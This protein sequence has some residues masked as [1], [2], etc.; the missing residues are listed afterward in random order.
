MTPHPIDPVDLSAYHDGAL[1]EADRRRVEEHLSVCRSCRERLEDY[2]WLGDALREGEDVPVPLTLDVRVRA[3][4]REHSAPRRRLPLPQ[5]WLPRPAMAAAVLAGLAM[6]LLLA[7]IPIL[8]SGSGPL[9]AAAYLYEEHGE[10]A[11]EVQF[12]APVDRDSVARSLQVDP[13]VEMEVT[14]RND[15]TMVV[16]PRQPQLLQP[17]K[18]YTLSLKPKGEQSAATPVALQFQGEV[19]STPVPLATQPAPTSP[20]ASRVVGTG[21]ATPKASA[22]AS[23]TAA[24]TLSPGGA[25]ALT[26]TPRP[27]V[28]P[29]RGFGALYLLQPDVAARLGPAYDPERP[30]T[31]LAQTFE[32]GQLISRADRK[33]IVALLE[34]SQW[35][36][37]PDTYDGTESWTPGSGE[38]VRSFGKLW[39]DQ[40]DLRQALGMPTAPEQQFEGAEQRF[41]RGTML[42]T[43]QR[44]IVVLFE[45]MTWEQYPDTYQEA[46]PTASPT[47]SATPTPT[48]ATPTPASPTATVPATPSPTATAEPSATSAGTPAE[49]TTT[50]TPVPSATDTPQ[51]VIPTPSP[52]TA[53]PTVGPAPALDSVF[54]VNPEVAIRLGAARTPEVPVRVAR[55]TFERGMLLSRA[56]TREIFAL[57]RDGSWLLYRDSWEE[58][59]PLS[60]EAAPIG[61]LAPLRGFGKLWRQQPDLR[62][63]F[64]WATAV[65][66]RLPGA[67]Q[68]FTDGH[69][70]RTSDRVIYVLYRDGSWQSFPEGVETPTPTPGVAEP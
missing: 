55:Q 11:I 59:E 12:T 30:V 40:T 8:D 33:E 34:G 2:G 46:T 63:S 65:E 39:R 57:R 56:D 64:G 9:V 54:R 16:K 6:T 26:A 3:L 68:E 27:T 52:A 36:S 29:A 67:A 42:R 24:A 45:D 31:L 32:R 47:A 53:T 66:Q 10:P 21:T 17:S 22:T 41:E 15:R 38:P 37:Y 70:L 51:A 43:A 62:Q 18:K 69:M 20:P 48:D 25:P 14:W 23:A 19:P 58:G 28:L 5:L 13:G 44:T 1:D 50:P 35:R 7:G 60:E 4:L 61:L 49:A